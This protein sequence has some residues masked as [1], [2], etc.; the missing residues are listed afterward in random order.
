MS[1]DRFAIQRIT[2]QVGVDCQV[3]GLRVRL[4]VDEHTSLPP[5]VSEMKHLQREVRHSG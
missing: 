4:S 1:T 3:K 5:E 2:D